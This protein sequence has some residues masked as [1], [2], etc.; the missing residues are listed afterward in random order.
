M[1]HQKLYCPFIVNAFFLIPECEFK[2][3]SIAP[4]EINAAVST[5]GER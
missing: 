2:Q 1:A 3:K 4:Y 5:R